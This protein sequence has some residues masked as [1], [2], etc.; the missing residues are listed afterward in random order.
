MGKKV[1]Y[2]LLL[3]SAVA[4]P[5]F[6]EVKDDFDKNVDFSVTLETIHRALTAQRTDVLPMEKAVILDGA[7]SSIQI[8]DG[9]PESFSAEITIV[10]GRWIGLEEVRMYSCIVTVQGPDF[11]ARIPVRRSRREVRNEISANSHIIVVGRITDF[12]NESGEEPA[13]VL[14]GFYI[15]TI[16]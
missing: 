15:R 11:A 5:V 3:F 1:V 8:I 12:R 16:D 4:F 2:I 13:A 10:D 9:E 6:S 14:E 7:I